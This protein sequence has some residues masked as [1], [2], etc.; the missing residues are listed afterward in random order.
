MF[1]YT[2]D[3]RFIDARTQ[4]LDL[5]AVVH[6]TASDVVFFWVLRL[7]QLPS[8]SFLGRGTFSTTSG[9]SSDT[10]LGILQALLTEGSAALLA[11]LHAMFVLARGAG[12]SS[13]HTGSCEEQ[14]VKTRTGPQQRLDHHSSAGLPY[15][16]LCPGPRLEPVSQ[17]PSKPATA[18]QALAASGMAVRQRRAGPVAEAAE[19][20][21]RPA[22]QLPSMRDCISAHHQATPTALEIDTDTQMVLQTLQS[23]V[24]LRPEVSLQSDGPVTKAATPANPRSGFGTGSMSRVLRV[25]Q[26][27]S[28]HRRRAED[29]ETFSWLKLL[30]LLTACTAGALVL[31][32]VFTSR[33][34]LLHVRAYQHVPGVTLPAQETTGL[35]QDLNAPVRMLL[36]ARQRMS[37]LPEAVED[38]EC[39]VHEAGRVDRISIDGSAAGTPLWMQSEDTTAWEEYSTLLV[40][41]CLLEALTGITGL[42]HVS[43]YSMGCVLAGYRASGVVAE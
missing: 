6:N 13:E 20:L 8:G 2:R 3:G 24:S 15:S 31:A 30:T 12:T 33:A 4:F 43:R 17:H 5:C 41:L 29:A 37:V 18:A 22:Q 28:T 14:G 40:R 10:F 27:A 16:A 38:E 9:L 35:Y 32:F 25:E 26:S 39:Q 1:Q 36:P 7:K 42:V 11:L 23:V 34:A 21:A 19:G